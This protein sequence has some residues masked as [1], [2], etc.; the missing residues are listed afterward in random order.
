M[1]SDSVVAYADS[2]SNAPAAAEKAADRDYDA[3]PAG[4]SST[5][6]S[7]T[8]KPS[9]RDTTEV[10]LKVTPVFTSTVLEHRFWRVTTL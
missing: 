3:D 1:S 6:R 7:V 10:R 8:E 9:L 4:K 5:V 2:N